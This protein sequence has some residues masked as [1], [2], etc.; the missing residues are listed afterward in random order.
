MKYFLS[1]GIFFFFCTGL[2]WEKFR[3]ISS[4][5][6]SITWAK[7]YSFSLSFS[8]LLFQEI[9]NGYL[10]CGGGEDFILLK[11]SSVGEPIWEYAYDRG[12]SETFPSSSSTSSGI[13]LGGTSLGLGNATLWLLRISSEGSSISWQ[14]T[15]NASGSLYARYIAYEDPYLFIGGDLNSQVYL[16]KIDLSGNLT[17]ARYYSN[18]TSESLT[19]VK[20]FSSKLLL[21][22]S[23]SSSIFLY[24]VFLNGTIDFAQKYLGGSSE[25]GYDI[26]G[27]SSGYAIIGYTNLGGSNKVLLLKVDSLGN[28]LWAK[29]YTLPTSSSLGKALFF[30]SEGSYLLIGYSNS[31]LGAGGQDIFL[32][33]VDSSGNPLWGKLI[34][35]S[36][37]EYGSFI[38]ET[39]QGYYVG[40]GYGGNTWILFQ[41]DQEGRIALKT[42]LLKIQDVLSSLIVDSYSF[43]ATSS[44]LNTT[45][46][47]IG[48]NATGISPSSLSLSVEDL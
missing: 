17:F 40:G 23:S 16:S 3:N 34:G 18:A 21:T 43:N 4:L 46:I 47:S 12:G 7:R 22:G 26:V 2:N 25:R 33:K 36:S 19:N 15:Y 42:S 31:T 1:L 48:K 11:T 20:I 28:F 35:T 38:Y 37:D 32:L 9:S 29:G 24:R 14:Y 44:S 5:S 41:M 13:F 45:P 30:T 10:F 27:D 39:S 8:S 6:S